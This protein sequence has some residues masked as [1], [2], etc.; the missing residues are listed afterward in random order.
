MLCRSTPSHEYVGIFTANLDSHPA[1]QDRL[2]PK[3]TRLAGWAALVHGLGIAAPVRVSSAIASGYIKGSNREE[4][5]WTVVDRR[6]WPGHHVMD[7]IRFALRHEGF[8]PL[9]LKR[10]FDAVEPDS[11]SDFVRV[12]PTVTAVDALDPT[13]SYVTSHAALSK[14]H[15]GR[16]NLLGAG[17]CF[18]VI[19]RI[20]S[21]E[22][23]GLPT[24]LQKP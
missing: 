21:I 20:K 23:A 16:D 15:R 11:I 14:R 7:H 1:F 12:A 6:Y 8:D 4:E 2:V 17:G 13:N 19:R 22:N 3:E 10:V 9:L 24:K 5:G 18:P